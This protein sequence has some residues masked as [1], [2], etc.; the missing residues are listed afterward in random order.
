MALSVAIEQAR[1]QA[2]RPTREN[3]ERQNRAELRLEEIIK[4]SGIADDYAAIDRRGDLDIETHFARLYQQAPDEKFRVLVTRAFVAWQ[5]DEKAEEETVYGSVG[6]AVQFLK[7][8][9]DVWLNG[10]RVPA[11]SDGVA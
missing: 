3:R 11:G 6:S 10:A 7:D 5:R 4:T 9:N 8:N 1:R 2:R